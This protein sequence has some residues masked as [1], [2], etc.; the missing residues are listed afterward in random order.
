MSVE[1]K[2]EAHVA[3]VR[4]IPGE[5]TRFWVQSFNPKT[6]EVRYLVDIAAHGEDCGQ[7]TCIRWD[8]KC[9]PLIRDTKCLPPSKRCRHLKAGREMALKLT[10]RQHLKERGEKTNEHQRT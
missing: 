7:C 5:P 10:I 9:W 6:P 8:T 3:V 1:P 4:C 2:A